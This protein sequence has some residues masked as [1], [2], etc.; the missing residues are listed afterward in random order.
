MKSKNVETKKK[1][2]KKD[3]ETKVLEPGQQFFM[4]SLHYYFAIDYS[5]VELMKPGYKLWRMKKLIKEGR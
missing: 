3:A 4:N 1:L 2:K 5:F